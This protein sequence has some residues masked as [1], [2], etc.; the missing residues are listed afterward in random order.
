MF[1][2]RYIDDAIITA[3]IRHTPLYDPRYDPIDNTQLK[4]FP[5]TNYKA[6]EFI[7]IIRT[8]L[9]LFIIISFLINATIIAKEVTLEKENKLKVSAE[10]TLDGWI[11]G[12]MDGRKDGWMDGGWM[13]GWM[14]GPRSAITTPSPAL[15][16]SLL[17]SLFLSL[18]LTL[19]YP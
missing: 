5:Y 13:F 7:D 17:L 15:T 2:Q 3:L 1:L 11:D 19:S 18:F 14:D 4:M 12:W 10:G 8:Y 6:D 9:P 16:L